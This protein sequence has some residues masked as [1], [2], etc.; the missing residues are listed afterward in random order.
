MSG[1]MRIGGIAS[2]FDTE[3]TVKK[4]MDAEK[5]R[6]NKYFQSK[7]V[8]TWKQEAYNSFNK[9]LASFVNSTSKTMGISRT[10]NGNIYESAR[11]SMTWLKQASSSDTSI[12]KVTSGASTPTGAYQVE[13]EEL[14]EGI[15]LYSTSTPSLFTEGKATANGSFDVYIAGSSD[16]INVEYSVGDT[17]TT[18]ANKITGTTYTDSSGNKQSL[19][20]TASYDSRSSTFLVSS[21]NT[22]KDVTLKM[23]DK[24]GSF[25]NELG[26]KTSGGVAVDFS[27][28]ALTG[29]NAKFKVD[30]VP[31]EY[32]TNQF[33]FNGMTVNAIGK[34]TTTVNV[35]TDVDG[36]YKVI[37]EFIDSYNTLIDG[38]N[39]KTSEKV[40]KD[41]KPLL[42]EQ[43][44][45]MKDED[46]KLWDEK[47]KSGLLKKDSLLTGV[48]E[49]MRGWL[50]EKVEGASGRYST[51]YEIG[52][53]TTSNYKDPG[54]LQ[55]N[56]TKLKEALSQDP[57]SVMDVLF[58][59]SDATKEEKDMNATEIVDKRKASGFIN[60]VYDE[61]ISGMKKVVTKS[62]PGEN[63]S[64]LRSVQA[65]ILLEFTTKGAYGRGN[66]SYLDRDI[67]STELLMER[68]LDRLNSRENSYWSRFTAMEKAISNMNSQSSWISSQMM[69]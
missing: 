5:V 28:G 65:T 34:G 49:S 44:S 10:V 60:R 58:K 4:L 15:K 46:I 9:D 36:A 26:L 59:N 57:E 63:S 43:K 21:K 39:K 53:E 27:S 38:I 68:E 33:V 35:N 50:Y 29:K 11:N 67:S 18:I 30:G 56:E 52:I 23:V 31:L 51:I 7:Q 12:A 24:V 20:I 8:F 22:G 66:E 25:V 47:A 16:P 2:G 69:K 32:N 48:S 13:V 3:S 54:K 55:I 40:Y 45:D 19:G 6:Y 37:K 61:M 64:L 42:D 1:G 62:G 17:L 41:F 14:A